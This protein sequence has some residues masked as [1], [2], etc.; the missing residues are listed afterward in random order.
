MP[1]LVYILLFIAVATIPFALFAVLSGVGL[2]Q[3]Y[4]HTGYYRRGP[5]FYFIDFD[6]D[7]YR[8]RGYGSG[9]YQGGGY[10]SGK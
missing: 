6:F 9:A 2:G 1:R 8:G 10:R 5:S 7:G 3:A 4:S